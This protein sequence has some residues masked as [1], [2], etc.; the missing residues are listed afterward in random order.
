MCETEAALRPAGCRLALRS[1]LLGSQGSVWGCALFAL[2]SHPA[3]KVS[4]LEPSPEKELHI[5]KSEIPP[6]PSAPQPYFFSQHVCMKVWR[7][8]KLVFKLEWKVAWDT[9]YMFSLDSKSSLAFAMFSWHSGY[10]QVW[11][12][13][14]CMTSRSVWV[15][16]TKSS[17]LIHSPGKYS[18]SLSDS[19]FL[20]C[21]PALL[22]SL[23]VIPH[24]G[25]AGDFPEK[26]RKR[27]C[28][29]SPELTDL[30]AK[31][32]KTASLV[33]KLTDSVSYSSIYSPISCPKHIKPNSNGIIIEF[34]F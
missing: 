22:G 8:I 17:F 34:D 18:N 2:Q 5:W 9:K 29:L 16:L 14:N 19:C 23:G 4:A 24:T 33:Q 31:S 12:Y 13:A 11:T 7:S 25:P 27:K 32:T 15:F 21:E 26:K 6:P 1:C 20:F 3:A 10:K 30:P 28:R